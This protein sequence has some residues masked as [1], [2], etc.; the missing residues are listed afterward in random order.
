MPEDA[1][2][3]DLLRLPCAAVLRG[4]RD[5]REEL[6]LFEGGRCVRIEVTAGTL[7]AGPVRLLYTLAGFSELEPKLLTLRRLLALRRLGRLPATLYPPERRA[8]RWAMAFQ[9]YDGARAG[10]THREIA[11]ALFGAKRVETDWAAGEDMRMRVHRLI[12][13]AER[14]VEGGYLRL[15]RE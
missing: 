7:L 5:G 13:T 12:R 10:A 4:A 6:L 9:A 3:I 2:G 1:D 14:L 8:R 11:I 15:L